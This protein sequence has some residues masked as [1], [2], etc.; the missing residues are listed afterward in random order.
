MAQVGP[1]LR[2]T[3]LVIIPFTPVTRSG[4]PFHCFEAS[5]RCSSL[6]QGEFFPHALRGGGFSTIFLFEKVLFQVWRSCEVLWLGILGRLILPYGSWLFHPVDFLPL[7]L[8][9]TLLWLALYLRQGYIYIYILHR[10]YYFCLYACIYSGV[11][12]AWTFLC[13]YRSCY[14]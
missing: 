2:V 4:T 1:S 8:G 6:C 14:V 13:G 7:F 3:Y 12:F 9:V 11:F 5:L 10:L